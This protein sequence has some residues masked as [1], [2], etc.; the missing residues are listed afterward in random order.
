MRSGHHQQSLSLS[1]SSYRMQLAYSYFSLSFSRWG[2]TVTHVIMSLLRKIK[3]SAR[4]ITHVLMSEVS[5]E[6]AAQVWA[7]DGFTVRKH[8]YIFKS[9]TREIK[10]CLTEC[11]C[12]SCR[13]LHT[14]EQEKVKE[15][16]TQR[17]NICTVLYF[18]N[19]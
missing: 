7:N 3:S 18:F 6:M 1:L 5:W 15:L 9:C 12:V 16:D 4:V 10:M 2:Y 17:K 13:T 11:S 19:I 8:D 14:C